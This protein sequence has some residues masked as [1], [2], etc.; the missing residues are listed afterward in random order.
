MPAFDPDM[1]IRGVA[2]TIPTWMAAIARAEKKT[3]M[4]LASDYAKRQIAD[5]LL[6]LEKQIHETLEAIGC[7]EK[8]F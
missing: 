4:E 1:E 3:D 8:E 6:Q 7:T 5:S 2:L